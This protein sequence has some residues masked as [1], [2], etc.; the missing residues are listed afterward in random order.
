MN[1]QEL[2]DQVKDDIL[3]W[4]AALGYRDVVIKTASST[5]GTVVA[6]ASVNG[7][8]TIMNIIK[9][10][11]EFFYA[12]DGAIVFRFNPVFMTPELVALIPADGGEVRWL[13]DDPHGVDAAFSEIVIGEMVQF[14][15]GYLDSQIESWQ[16]ALHGRIDR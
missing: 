4:A 1:R 12:V 13:K 16:G 6:A 8:P 9:E 5:A 3:E 7:R 14:Y 15:Q 11:E 2:I 10:G